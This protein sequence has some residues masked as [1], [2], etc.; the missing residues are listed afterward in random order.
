MEKEVKPI[1]Y[2][3]L[4]KR[5]N[6]ARKA[7]GYSQEYVA[8]KANLSTS[9]MSLIENGNSKVSLPTLVLLASIL[10]T[11][12]DAL[13]YDEPETQDTD[14]IDN[15]KIICSNCTEKEKAYLLKLLKTA[16][17]GFNELQ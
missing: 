17:E 15:V 8:N 10:E 5:I 11:T 7:L 9:Y 14:F 6:I 1:D 4:G 16:R 13:L 12:V 2:I 3:G